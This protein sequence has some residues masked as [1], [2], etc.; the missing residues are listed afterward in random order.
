MN[1]KGAKEKKGGK[2]DSRASGYGLS[3]HETGLEM[4]SNTELGE[5]PHVSRAYSE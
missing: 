2:Y 5:H 4:E 1:V 3:S